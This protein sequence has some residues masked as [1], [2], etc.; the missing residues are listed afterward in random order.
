VSKGRNPKSVIVSEDSP[1]AEDVFALEELSSI[2]PE[3]TVTVSVENDASLLEDVLPVPTKDIPRPDEDLTNDQKAQFIRLV[4]EN[5]SLRERAEQL[6]KLA[7]FTD[8]KRAPVAL[9]AIQFMSEIDG[10]SEEAPTEAPTMFQL[11]EGSKMA[12]AIKTPDK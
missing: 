3:S 6:V 7:R 2:L 1:K 12:I 4:R 5:M 11:P 8:T 9:R 10:I